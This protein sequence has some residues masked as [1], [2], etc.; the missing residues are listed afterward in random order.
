MNLVII[1]EIDLILKEKNLK[2]DKNIK[3][4]FLS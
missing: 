3:L 2:L 4:Y 1:K